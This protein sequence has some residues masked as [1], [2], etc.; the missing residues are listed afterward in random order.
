M[1]MAI[2]CRWHGCA[3][4]LRGVG[5][6]CALQVKPPHPERLL[7][8]RRRRG[9]DN[10]I[11]CRHLRTNPLKK[12]GPGVHSGAAMFVGLILAGEPSEDV[13]QDTA[14]LVVE[15]FLRRVDSNARLEGCLLPV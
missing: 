15:D 12:A 7:F 10:G 1:G 11:W 6:P 9:T 3:W 8:A 2:G 13:L 5:A 14:V 4:T